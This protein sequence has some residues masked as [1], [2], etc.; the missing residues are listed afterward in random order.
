ME[1]TTQS[2]V[3]AKRGLQKV[4]DK[5]YHGITELWWLALALKSNSTGAEEEYHWLGSIPGLKELLGEITI[6]NLLRHGF[7]I[8]NK[9]WHDTI[10]IK[11]VD[12][13]RDRLGV[14]NPLVE[15]MAESA[16][17]HPGELLAQLMVD[18]FTA[19]DYTK[20]PF[21]ATGKKA[22]AKAVAFSNKG[23]KK[24]SQT[25][26]R[27]ARA[28]LT[29]RLNSAGRAMRL[30]KNLLLIVSPT[31]EAT[32]KEITTAE[33]I[34][35]NTNIDRGTA[36]VLVLP[37][38][39][40]LNAEHNWFLVEVGSAMKPFILQTEVAPRSAMCT[41]PDDSHV[42]KTGE[43]IYQVNAR[44]NAGYGLPELAYGSTGAADA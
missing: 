21:F 35:N 5:A 23:T 42:I 32:A 31:Y 40:A 41:D 19:T 2:L 37:E 17:N 8:K 13:E 27:T 9:E 39:L 7:T 11:R 26:F 34:N 22:H 38:L 12:I 29:G 10:G 25:N 44:H 36:T 16:A 30:G 20:T 4:F 28:N 1:I 18:G 15:L 43:F 14:Y 3:S 24:L 33:K 6:S